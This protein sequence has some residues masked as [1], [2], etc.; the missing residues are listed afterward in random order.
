VWAVWALGLALGAAGAFWRPGGLHVGQWLS[1][2]VE[3]ALVPRKAV[4]KPV[5]KGVLWW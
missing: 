5:G 1:V 3:W 4:W 2:A